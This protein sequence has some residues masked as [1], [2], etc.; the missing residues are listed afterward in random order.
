MDSHFLRRFLFV[1]VTL[2]N[3]LRFTAELSDL[4]MAAGAAAVAKPFWNPTVPSY[5]EFLHEMGLNSSHDS[6]VLRL[7]YILHWTM[8]CEDT[9]QHRKHELA[10]L[11][12]GSD[13]AHQTVCD[14]EVVAS[15]LESVQPPY[16]FIYRYRTQPNCSCSPFGS[17]N[18]LHVH[19]ISVVCLSGLP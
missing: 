10:V 15:M 9:F 18:A 8:G 2:V 6:R 11:R 14:D 13:S 16:G 7:K 5:M 19:I 3:K 17:S 1:V 12:H 4:H